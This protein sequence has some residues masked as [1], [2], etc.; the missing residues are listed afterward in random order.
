MPWYR[1]RSDMPGALAFGRFHLKL[2]KRHATPP[3]SVCGYVGD[4]MCDWKL[5][6]D[7]RNY[8]APRRCGR[9]LCI[10][11]TSEPALDKDLCPEHELA[12]RALLA[13]R[14]NSVDGPG[15]LA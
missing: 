10:H 13:G 4:R 1:M 8:G 11:C 6:K 12:W 14:T 7:A 2:S 5:G 9:W 15:P 3:C